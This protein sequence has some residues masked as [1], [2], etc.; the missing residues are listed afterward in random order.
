M[1]IYCQACGQPNKYG[2]VKPKFCNNCGKSLNGGHNKPA[3]KKQPPQKAK[4]EEELE[5]DEIVSIP[6]LS[7]LEAE[8]EAPKIRGVKLGEIAGTGDTNEDDD[9]IPPQGKNVSQEEFLDQF[10]REAGSLRKK[11]DN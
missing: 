6:D 8:I 11:G 10:Q 7:K 4:A 5:E 9:F 1:N 3:T 2:S